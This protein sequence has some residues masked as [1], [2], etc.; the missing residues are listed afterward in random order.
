MPVRCAWAITPLDMAYHD[1]EWGVPVH[2]DRRLFEFLVLEGA[3]AGLSWATI[4]KKRE[5]YRRAFAGFDPGRVAA[6]AARDVA[7]LMTDAGIVRNRL[8]IESAIS[9]AGAFGR[10]Q[11]AF[12]SFDRLP[13]ALCRRDAAAAR[14]PGPGP[15][16]CPHGGVRYSVEGPPAPGVPVRRDDDLLRVHAGHGTG[17]RPRGRLLSPSGPCRAA[18]VGALSI[19][20]PTIVSERSHCGTCSHRIQLPSRQDVA[21]AGPSLTP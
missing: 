18:A 16:P 17:Q 14:L 11:D 9:N 20:S 8:K 5:N 19:C 2:D 1:A 4:L 21:L 12:G 13:V 10:V 7:R 15:S 6:F 3:Q